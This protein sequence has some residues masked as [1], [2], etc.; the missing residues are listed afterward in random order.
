MKNLKTMLFSFIVIMAG[1]F[2]LS[3][4]TASE[5]DMSYYKAQFL[6]K[7][8]EFVVVNN[9]HNSNL[10]DILEHADKGLK[11]TKVQNFIDQG[12][13]QLEL[14]KEDFATSQVPAE[15]ESM[16]T[17]ILKAI[18]LRIKAYEDLFIYYD[19]KEQ[20]NHRKDA[21]NKINEAN[22]LMDEVKAELENFK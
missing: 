12:K 20:S 8:K 9:N 17:K 5:A 10:K 15:L 14:V 13:S 16:K 4:C 21:E 18:D 22:G 19:M 3:G 2:I 7:A 6:E 11:R 1:I